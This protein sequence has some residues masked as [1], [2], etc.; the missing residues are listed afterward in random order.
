MKKI[1]V[2]L[3]TVLMALTSCGKSTGLLN[4]DKSPV[5]NSDRRTGSEL[6]KNIKGKPKPEIIGKTS[7]P[8]WI[9]EYADVCAN[10]L[11]EYK[12]WIIGTM[13]L[14]CWV[15]IKGKALVG[16]DLL[17]ADTDSSAIF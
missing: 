11:W 17:V 4:G 7:E 10:V 3:M 14:C 8:F 13:V 15:G 5:L 12:W 16:L 1:I 6:P 2:L 9:Y